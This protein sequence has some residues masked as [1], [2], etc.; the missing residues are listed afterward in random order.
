MAVTVIACIALTAANGTQEVSAGASTSGWYVSTVPATGGDDILLGSSCPNALQCFATGV[1]IFNINATSTYAP[2]VE[3]WNGSSW[4]KSSAPVPAGQGGGIFDVSCLNGTNCWGVGTVINE[5]EGTGNPSGTLI[6]HWDGTAWSIVPSPNPSDANVA[7]A[8]LQSVSCASPSSCVA[9]GYASDANGRNLNDLIEQWNGSSWSISPGA[10][11][12]Q[13]FGQLTR[14]DCLSANDCWAVGNAGPVPQNPNFLPIFPGAVGDQGLIEHWNGSAWSV[15]ES[16]TQSS[17]NGG[18]LYGLT[19]LNDTDCWASGATTD[20]SG[21]ASGVLVEHWNGSSWADISST[22]PEPQASTGAILSSIS[23]LTASACWAV[24][25]YGT[26]G[27][28]GGSGFQPQGFIE[29]WN[30]SSWSVEP[31]PNVTALSFLNSVSCLPS[32][33]CAAVGGSATALQNDPGLRPYIEQMTFPPGSS[34]GYALGAQDGGVF[35]Y[36]ATAFAGSMGGQHLNAPVVGI[37]PTPD[38]QGYWLVASDGGVFAFGDARFYGSMGG[39]PLNRPVVGIAPTP[40]GRGYWLVASDGGVFSFG[41]ARFHGSMGRQRLNA[42]VV[43][44]AT[45]DIGG[46]WLVGSDGGIFSFGG[47]GFFGSAGSLHLAAPVSGMAATPNGQGYWLVARDGGVFTYG[48]ATYLGSVPGQGISG[49]PAVVGMAGTPSG[50]GYWLAG[51][52]GAV[53]SYG[54]AS[55]LGTPNGGRLVAPVVGISVP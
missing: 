52:N 6:E 21:Q 9:V 33:G 42:P 49:Q 34:Q 37:A 41:D 47:A 17:P 4:A 23:C 25:S 53:Y 15:V 43:G 11:T 5:T 20:A 46:Y 31:S 44:I 45:S 16:A 50:S 36:G 32:V 48:N 27:G 39:Q 29:N 1:T 14:V 19:C 2:L 35:A 8:L 40:D 22:V 38:G 55:F 30:G 13:P 7:G 3:R 26:F 10:P 28:G 12:G 54:D 51:A 18:Y 24:G